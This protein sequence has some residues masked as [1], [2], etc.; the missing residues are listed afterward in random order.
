MRIADDPLATLAER[1]A[2]ARPMSPGALS[3]FL[4][5]TQPARPAVTAWPGFDG[6]LADVAFYQGAGGQWVHCRTG[7]IW[8]GHHG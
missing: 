7:K 2:V 5:P 1:C 8:E 4:I 3:L 6:M